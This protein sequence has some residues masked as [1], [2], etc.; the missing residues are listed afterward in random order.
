ML[1][2]NKYYKNV[3]KCNKIVT[4]TVDNYVDMWIMTK[5]GEKNMSKE[6]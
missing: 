1:T 5:K 2:A 4:K 3:T 6:R